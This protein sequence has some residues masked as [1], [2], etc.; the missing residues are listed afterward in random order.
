MLGYNRSPG[1]LQAAIRQMYEQ[2]T[3]KLEIEG[4]KV[5]PCALYEAMNGKSEDHYVARVEPSVEG[6][7]RLA[8]L[9]VSHLNSI[10]AAA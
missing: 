1:Q 7:R 5:I 3:A 9:L 8:E 10:L 6:G 2:A 4:T